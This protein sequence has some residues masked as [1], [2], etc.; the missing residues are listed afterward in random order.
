MKR[1]FIVA[2]MLLG[3]SG[4]AF[5]QNAN[6][7]EAPFGL[8]PLEVFSIFNQNFTN[9]DYQGAIDFGRWLILAH[10]KQMDL[11]GNAR[12]SGDRNFNRMIT[13]YQELGKQVSDPVA[14][15]AYVDSARGLYE[16]V[17]TLFSADEIDMYR[18]RFE[19]GRFFQVNT[20]IANNN[21]LAAEQ[22]RILYDLDRERLVKEANGYYIQFIVSLIVA[23][24][25]R[26]A[27]IALMTEA[28]PFAGTE[29]VD[30]FNSVRDRLF[31]NPEERIVYL[32]ELFER[33]PTDV[34]MIGELYDLYVRVNNRVKV[35]ESAR[36]LYEL[37]PSYTNTMRMAAMAANNASYTDAIRFLQEALTKTE[38]RDQRKEAT[39]QIA[40]N[41][42][43]MDN[44][45]QARTFARRAIEIDGSW[46]QP[47]MRIAD[48]YAQ[49]VSRC[50][51]GTMTREDKVVYWLVL[52]YLDRARNADA[53]V[54]QAVDRQI[55]TYSAVTPSPEEKFFMSWNTGDRMRVDGSLK[56]CYA[57]IG[58]TTTVR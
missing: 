21:Q 54:R 13:V 26:D 47:Y 56:E 27:A 20:S 48:I 10:P 12:Y 38:D 28:E 42:I 35:V 58:E 43:N 30:Y 57:W 19:Y 40:D 50:A 24:G 9:R 53:S 16:R 11:P 18:W 15:S 51:G 46:G 44:L 36:K 33:N 5:A 3:L 52:D 41:Y 39:L 8:S 6:V 29:T 1:Y 4:S 49:S 25:E 7:P 14:K 55:R 45:Q 17:F 22:Y 34:A 32:E 31:S 23:N 37:N 2:L